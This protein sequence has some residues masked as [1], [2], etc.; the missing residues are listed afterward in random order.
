[1][2]NTTATTESLTDDQLAGWLSQ[3]AEEGRELRRIHAES[4]LGSDEGDEA[5]AKLDRLIAEADEL[6][7]A[8]RLC[9]L[10]TR[11]GGQS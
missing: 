8:L 3:A 7:C 6:G 9:R 5:L 11:K 2:K 10:L 4:Q 1:M